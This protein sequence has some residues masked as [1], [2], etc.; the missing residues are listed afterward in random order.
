[1]IALQQLERDDAI[2]EIQILKDKLDK[3]Q[4]SMSKAHEERENA[5][6][7]FEKMLEKYDR[8]IYYI[9]Q[10]SIVS[11]NCPLNILECI[12]ISLRSKNI[13]T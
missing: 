11:Q 9:K 7:E 6:K 5:S 1:M 3:A 8:Y 4:Y 12:L 2:T 10:S 13:L